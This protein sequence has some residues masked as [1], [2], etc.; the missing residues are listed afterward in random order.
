MTGAD[1]STD[2]PDNAG[3]LDDV[4]DEIPG[5]NLPPPKEEHP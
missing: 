2:E 4:V 5:K 3:L 1:H